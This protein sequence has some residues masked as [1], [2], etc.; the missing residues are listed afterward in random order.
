MGIIRNAMSV[1]SLRAVDYRSDKERTAADT[2]GARKQAKKQTKLIKEQAKQQS[3]HNTTMV[4]QAAL[5]AQP[6]QPQQWTQA[7]STV[8]VAPQP[9]APVIPQAPPAGWYPD[10]VNPAVVRWFDGQSW[11]DHTQPRQYV[12]DARD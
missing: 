2:K 10:Q 8:P 6:L 9:V 1:S 11:T 5:T 12:P 7:P 4:A 3:A